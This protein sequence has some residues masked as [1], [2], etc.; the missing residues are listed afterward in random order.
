MKYALGIDIGGTNFRIGVIGE[1]GEL[2][3]FEKKSSKIFNDCGVV[4]ILES[5]ISSYLKKNGMEGKMQ[6]A[7]YKIKEDL[8][9]V[10][11]TKQN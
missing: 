5:E 3:G 4:E 7:E 11:T 1:N 9:Y 8:S 10:C 2:I 6:K